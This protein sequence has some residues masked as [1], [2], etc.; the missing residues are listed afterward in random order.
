MAGPRESY[1]YQSQPAS[2]Q[3]SSSAIVSLIAGVLAWLGIF[4]LG[5]IVAVIFGHV[6][7]NEIRQSGGRIGGDGLATAGLILGYA[8]IAVAIIG[9]CLVALMFMGVLTVPL[10]LSLN[11]PNWD[12]SL[13][14]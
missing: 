1:T 14:P 6:A 4:G 5:G 10:C 2:E 12:F 13:I 9:A 8:N 3:T 7:K 11:A